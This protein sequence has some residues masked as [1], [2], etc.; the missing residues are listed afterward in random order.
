MNGR[1]RVCPGKN[2]ICFKMKSPGREAGPLDSP[3]QVYRRVDFTAALGIRSIETP[4]SLLNDHV[5]APCVSIHAAQA[6]PP[7]FYLKSCRPGYQI[8][9][10]KSLIYYTSKPRSRYPRYPGLLGP[11]RN[12]LDG[13]L[14]HQKNFANLLA[15]NAVLLSFSNR[16]NSNKG[17]K[18]DFGPHPAK[19]DEAQVI[20]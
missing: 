3:D 1:C 13:A 20:L 15:S 5:A 7:Q 12:Q 6:V 16:L 19:P 10:N 9:L 18:S 17:T 4:D 11:S 2:E 14:Y 8:S